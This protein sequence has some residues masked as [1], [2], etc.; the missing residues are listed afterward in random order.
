MNGGSRLDPQKSEQER[1]LWQIVRSINDAWTG[2]RTQLLGLYFDEAI[3]VHGAAEGRDEVV[4][5]YR[6]FVE[7]VEIE[8]F[9]ER[10]P[11]VLLYGPTAVVSYRFEIAWSAEG[12]RHEETGEEIWV[13]A[14]RDE[15]WK[16]V[17]RAM[18][19]APAEG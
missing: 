16:A 5:S 11:E 2:G 1:E 10:D 3:V 6:E 4:A 12:E 7:A 9:G 8:H 18:L 19:S 13:F 17:W 14:R 15:A